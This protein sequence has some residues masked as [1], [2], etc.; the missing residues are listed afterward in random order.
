MPEFLAG[1]SKTAVVTMSNL[2]EKA[3]DY[4]VELYMGTTL[5]LMASTPFHLEAKES[6]DINLT[7]TM[8][9]AVGI[10]PVYLGVF[11]DGVSIALY[12]AE[13]VVIVFDPWNYD[14]NGNGIIE[15]NEFLTAAN[16]YS[17]GIIT[18]AQF[19]Q[20]QALWELG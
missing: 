17:A 18:K 6:K 19:D 11:S 1:E 7:V 20:V 10:Y 12:Q 2:A 16:D 4:S 3:F 5:T 9:P 15:T 13:D 8:P 14:F